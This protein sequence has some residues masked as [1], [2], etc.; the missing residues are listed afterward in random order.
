MKYYTKNNKVKSA[1]QIVVY[2]NGMQTINPTEEL[3]LADGWIEY[4]PEVYEP[5][6]EDV[7]A[8]KIKEILDFDSSKEVNSFFIQNFEM[9][10]DKATRV[11]LNLRFDAEL[12]SGKEETVLWYDGMQFPLELQTAL[13]MLNAIELYASACYDNTQAHIANVKAFEFIEEIEDYNY[14][15]GYPEKLRF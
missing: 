11:G 7:R 13:Q 10:L 5:T 4:V 6:V 9:W 2:R 1:K 8:N 15:T 12:A 14:R 3:I